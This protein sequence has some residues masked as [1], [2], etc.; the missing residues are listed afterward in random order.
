LAALLDGELTP[1]AASAVEAHL[2]GCAAC[3]AACDEIRSA[4]ALATAWEVE[5]TD[6]LPA[7]RRQVADENVDA[8]LLE[9]GRLREEVAALR[10]EVAQLKSR[11]ERREAPSPPQTSV[12]RFPYVGRW[13]A[14]RRVV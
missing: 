12:L 8:I 3:S 10:L 11:E 14:L 9:M 2:S 7:I 13:D 1:E 6:L 5:E 4:L